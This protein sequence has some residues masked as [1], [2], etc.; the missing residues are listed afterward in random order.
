VLLQIIKGFL[1]GITPH[2]FSLT[3]TP[4]YLVEGPR[5]MGESQHEPVAEIG[6]PQEALKLSECGWGW[7]VMDDLDLIWIHIYTMLINNVA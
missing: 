5:N 1:L 3:T 4:S 6:K 2:K 7:S